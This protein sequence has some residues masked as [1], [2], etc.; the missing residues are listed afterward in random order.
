M[1][2]EYY[3]YSREGKPPKDWHR[4]EDHLKAVAEMAGTFAEDFRAGNWGYLACL[5]HDL[6]KYPREFQARL[7]AV[8]DPDAQSQTRRGCP[9]PSTIG[10]T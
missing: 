6:G 8:N 1:K 4:L 5:W 2:D 3:A 10:A 9:Y 7:L